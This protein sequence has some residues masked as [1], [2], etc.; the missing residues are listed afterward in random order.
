G[1]R[2]RFRFSA[3]RSAADEISICSGA[4]RSG[5]LS[6]AVVQPATSEAKA[7]NH[8]LRRTRRRDMPRRQDRQPAPGG[9]TACPHPY[10]NGSRGGTEA[11]PRARPRLVLDCARFPQRA[12]MPT[13]AA[14]SQQIW[15]MKYRLKNEKGEPVDRT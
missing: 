13:V 7:S 4:V 6:R 11:S 15:D 12:P 14:I 10:K 8:R 2:S 5:K 9:V 3:A 1:G